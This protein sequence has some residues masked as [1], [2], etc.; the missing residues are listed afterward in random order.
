MF[1]FNHLKD[2][3][4]IEQEYKIHDILGSGAYGEVRK[5]VHKKLGVERAVKIIQKEQMSK[6]DLETL[7]TEINILTDMDHPN[8]LKI[9]EAYQDAKK[10]YIVTELCQGGELFD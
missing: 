3:K 9:F 5:C 7:L 10:F 2:G 6:R 8:V 4:R 1:V